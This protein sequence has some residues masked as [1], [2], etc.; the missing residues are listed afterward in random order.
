MSPYASEVIPTI[1]KTLGKKDVDSIVIFGRKKLE[2]F[3]PVFY[4]VFLPVSSL[5][6]CGIGLI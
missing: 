6:T 1:T 3:L 4:V 5:E 2:V